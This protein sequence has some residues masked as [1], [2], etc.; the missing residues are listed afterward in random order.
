MRYYLLLVL[1]SAN[2]N[3]TRFWHVL[4]LNPLCCKLQASTIR[5]AF[6]ALPNQ[7]RAQCLHPRLR[8]KTLLLVHPVAL[9]RYRP[10]LR[11]GAFE[12]HVLRPVEKTGIPPPNFVVQFCCHYVSP[13]IAVGPLFY[14]LPRQVVVASFALALPSQPRQVVAQL[15]GAGDE[16]R[17]RDNLLGRQGLYQLSY[18]RR[19]VSILI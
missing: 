7:P 12:V 1:H 19:I 9:L 2:K 14:F 10:L 13:F 17:T 11:L 4:P 16:T 3:A 5:F 15:Y 8:P 6:S 18:S